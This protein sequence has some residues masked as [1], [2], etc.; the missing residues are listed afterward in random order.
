VYVRARANNAV[1]D[2]RPEQHEPKPK[3][4]EAAETSCMGFK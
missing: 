2:G 3:S 4:A 1:P